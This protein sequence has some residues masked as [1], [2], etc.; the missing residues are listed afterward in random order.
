MQIFIKL[1]NKE[2]ISLDVKPSDTIGDVKTKIQRIKE[3]RI[4]NQL[5]IYGKVELE[6]ER[7]LSN[8]KINSKAGYVVLKLHEKENF[9]IKIKNLSTQ[10]TFTIEMTENIQLLRH[11]ISQTQR[12]PMEFIKLH[13]GDGSFQLLEDY[14]SLRQ[15]QLNQKIREF[16]LKLRLFGKLFV[17]T[18]EG[19]SFDVEAEATDTIKDIKEKIILKTNI[20]LNT[21][22]ILFLDDGKDIQRLMDGN[23]LLTY[24]LS[25]IV[26][27]GI[28][29]RANM[30]VNIHRPI[31]ISMYRPSFNAGFQDEYIFV[32]TMTGKTFSIYCSSNDTVNNIKAKINDK[33]GICPDQQ[34]L[35]FAG[36]QLEDGRTL[37]DY[38]IR[39]ESTL[40]LI[41]MLTG[42]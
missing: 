14:E 28:L 21:P 1:R 22:Q 34:R 27:Y 16:G 25:K 24:N 9:V 41:L 15:T 2:T 23:T 3:I 33:E 7:K 17:K 18:F 31:Q 11:K 6:N 30:I 42:S 4:D 8:Y 5:L 20:D 19:R 35:I 13:I 29:L 12:L 37:S 10:A 39:K 32:K 26:R 36:N 40:H 38:N